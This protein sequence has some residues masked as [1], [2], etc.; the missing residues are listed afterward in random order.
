M[1]I[2]G[3]NGS[4]LFKTSIYFMCADIWTNQTLTQVKKYYPANTNI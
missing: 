3:S 4:K 2:V 1:N